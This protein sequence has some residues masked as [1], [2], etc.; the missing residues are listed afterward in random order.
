MRALV[1]LL[2]VWSK[3]IHTSGMVKPCTTA[4]STRRLRG[5]SP[6]SHVVRSRL[7]NTFPLGR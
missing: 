1:L 4:P 2:P 7:I 5:N 3:A 6:C